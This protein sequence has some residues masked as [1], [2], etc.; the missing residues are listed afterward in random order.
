MLTR[1]NYNEWCLLMRVNMEAQGF[2]YAVEPEEEEEVQYRDDCL[3][4]AAILRSVPPEMLASLSTKRTA[5]SAWEAI[6]SRRVGIQRVREANAKQLRRDFGDIRF[7]EGETIDN[8]S[9]RITGLANSI[10]VLG[11][12]VSEAEIVKKM[13]QVVPEHLEQVVISIE[14]LLDVDAMT[15]EEV[16]GR[17][18]NVEQRKKSASTVD[19]QGRLLLTQEEW[20]AWLKIRENSGNIG[21]SS[22][23]NGGTKLNQ[24]RPRQRTKDGPPRKNTTTEPRPG[25]CRTCGV[26]GHWARECPT[27]SKKK[28]K[29]NVVE[30]NEEEEPSLFLVSAHAE[31]D[32]VVYSVMSSNHL[33]EV[34]RQEELSLGVVTTPGSSPVQIKEAKVHAEIGERGSGQPH[35]WILDSGATNHMS[36]VRAAF[37]ELDLNVCGSVKFGDGSVAKIEGRG[38]ILFLGNKGEHRHLTG[39]YYIPRLKANIISLGQL[40][41]DGCDIVIKR[42]LL[43]IY[44]DRGQLLTKVRRSSSRLYI[45]EIRV[46]HPVSLAAKAEETFWRW[47]A[48]YG[49]LNFPALQRLAKEEMF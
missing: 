7:R 12:S 13:L 6:R 27:K 25:R 3:A 30:A 28:E 24:A 36:G 33:E 45:L 23:G 9:L 18:R 47:H 42:G 22:G 37:T 31:A 8:F 48:R 38:T 46:E 44:N 32:P 21:G 16:T 41:E 34:Q 43:R 35:R 20:L 19:N 5:Q 29:T 26:K 14:T 11:G 17:L 2:W 40:D 1:T 15:V 49:H 4:F 10:N 39:V